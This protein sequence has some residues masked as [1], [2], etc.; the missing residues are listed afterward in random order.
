MDAKANIDTT[1]KMLRQAKELCVLNVP[2]LILGRQVKTSQH[3][4]FHK[5]PYK[6][7]LLPTLTTALLQNCINY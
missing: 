3:S 6:A 5:R 1:M 4:Q 2:Q 7:R